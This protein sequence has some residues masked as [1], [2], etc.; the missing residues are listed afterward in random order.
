[1][2]ENAMRRVSFLSF[3]AGSGALAMSPFASAAAEPRAVIELFTSQGCSSCPPADQLLGELARDPS[4]VALS[5][6]VDYWDYLGWKDT[7]ANRGYTARQRRYA[8]SRGDRDVYT[9]Q[10]VVNGTVHVL[11]SDKEA[12]DRA[13]AQTR[14]ST[15]MIPVQLTRDGADRI[16]V[17]V[18]DA[19][20][21]ERSGEV[22]ICG[23]AKS[24]PVQIGRGENHGST[25]TYHNVG[26]RWLKLGVWNGKAATWTVPLDDIKADGV[27][28]A[29]V[30]LQTGNSTGPGPML[31]AAFTALK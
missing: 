8:A 20:D 2:Q 29:A 7:L 28:A 17:S 30:I 21:G 23:V 24:V 4:I 18:P 9:P 6:P 27:D 31:G 22:W 14:Q 10:V 13:I 25:I 11:G 19:K 16:T 3:V 26:R 1:M 15:M 5:L 12:I